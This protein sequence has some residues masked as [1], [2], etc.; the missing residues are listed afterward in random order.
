MISIG[1]R[2]CLDIPRHSIDT[3]TVS[4]GELATKKHS[5]QPAMNRGK[6]AGMAIK[7]LVVLLVGL[8]LASVGLAEAQQ[9]GKIARIGVLRPG[10]PPESLINAFRQRLRDLGYVQGKN[11]AFEY[12]YAD[13]K[14]DRLP[15]LAAE[16]VR[17]KV[18]VIF[19]RTR[20]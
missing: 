9:P 13:G 3:S 4:G 6:Q 11:I 19:S 17:L 7:T 10:S 18:D 15:E 1:N 14:L 8:A 2:V 16:L 5:G 12:R 20:W